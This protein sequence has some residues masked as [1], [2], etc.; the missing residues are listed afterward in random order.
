MN[1]P[2][3]GQKKIPLKNFFKHPEKTGYQ[4]SPEGKYISYLAP[5]KNRMNLFVQELGAKKAV[6]ITSYTDRDLSG[7]FWKSDKRLVFLKDN[8]GDENFHLYAV[9]ANGENIIDMTPFE[10]VR[11]GIVDALE[12]NDNKMLIQSRCFL[13]IQFLIIKI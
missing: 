2:T 8:G 6:Q 5:Y 4:I 11:A 7:Y 10:N 1:L 13:I 9:S 12:D 3:Q